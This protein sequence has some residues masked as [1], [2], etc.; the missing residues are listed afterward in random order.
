MF[1]QRPSIC[2]NNQ[3]CALSEKNSAD[4]ELDMEKKAIKAVHDDDLVVF[5]NGLGI[6]SDFIH[7]KLS[8][9]FCKD[10]ITVENLH[11]LFPDSGAI[12]ICCSK[13]DCIHTLF[14]A[15][16]ALRK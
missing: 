14:A 1:G 16:E 3:T 6:Y 15:R 4:W 7:N 2:L 8:C 13:P 11:A 10:V 12:K 9:A 5:L